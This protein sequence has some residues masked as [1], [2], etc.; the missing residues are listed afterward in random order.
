MGL[1]VRQ[2]GRQ[3]GSSQGW[4][5]RTGQIVAQLMQFKMCLGVLALPN[6]PFGVIQGTRL[7]GLPVP[8]GSPCPTAPHAQ[9][10]PPLRAS[11]PLLSLHEFLVYWRVFLPSWSDAITT[12]VIAALR[13][14]GDSKALACMG[15][16]DAP[17]LQGQDRLCSPL[18]CP[19]QALLGHPFMLWGYPPH[20]LLVG[21]LGFTSCELGADCAGSAVTHEGP[22]AALAHGSWA[23]CS[24][25]LFWGAAGVLVK[26]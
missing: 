26:S 9:G 19:E 10:L 23:S 12:S 18:T 5:G 8:K 6:V 24:L 3:L 21:A 4:P 14:V 25:A 22:N 16:W 20:D 1:P 17:L 7:R 13:E 15:L 11:L 2:R